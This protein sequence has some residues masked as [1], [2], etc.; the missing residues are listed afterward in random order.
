MITEL[1]VL[2][3]CF[4][5]SALLTR[6]LIGHA[7]Q[8][9]FLDIPNERSSHSRPTP[10]GGGLAIVTA[11]VCFLLGLGLVSEAI[12]AEAFILAFAGAVLAA[13]GYIDD[14]RHIS[15]RWRLL[16]HFGV[17]LVLL[18]SLDNL[19]GLSVLDWHWQ[20]G[21]ILSVMYLVALVWLLNLFNFMDGIDGAAGVEAVTCLCGAALLMGLSG[22]KQWAIVLLALSFSVLGFLVFNWPPAKIFMGDAGSGFLGLMLGAL[23]LIT[24]A[25][26]V[27]NLW[28]WLILLAVFIS[29][30]TITLF[31]RAFRGQRVYEAHRSH[32]YQILSRRWQSH[33]RVTLLVLFINL[34]WLF[35]VAWLAMIFSDYGFII[36]LLAYAP[37]SVFF[38][39][40]GAGTTNN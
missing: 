37:V 16:V 23:A 26:E 15:A 14:H 36:T 25:T 3:G 35:P 12:G 22:D 5:V 9:H 20:S 40:I 31:R 39:R 24:S 27:I 34:A 10:T 13:V 33:R 29:D 2:A 11:F 28:C 7:Q 8:R 32:A 21:W 38:Y 19:P 4:A 17:G 6:Y 1:L 18:L 30:S